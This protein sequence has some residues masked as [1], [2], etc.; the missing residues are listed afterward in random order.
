MRIFLR[1]L[2]GVKVCTGT[3]WFWGV[4]GDSNTLKLSIL[5]FGFHHG[6]FTKGHQYKTVKGRAP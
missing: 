5:E 2:L 6:T 3:R 1:P 4:L